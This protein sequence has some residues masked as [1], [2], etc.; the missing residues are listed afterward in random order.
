MAVNFPM[1]FESDKNGR[2]N[3]FS[4]VLEPTVAPIFFQ[5]IA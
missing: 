5:K 1:T 3:G 4:A 2:V